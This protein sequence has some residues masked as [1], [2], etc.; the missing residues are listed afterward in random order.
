VGVRGN[1]MHIAAADRHAPSPLQ[2]RLRPPIDAPR[3]GRHPAR[4]HDGTT[5]IMGRV[6]IF[7]LAVLLSATA[8]ATAT[9]LRLGLAV[10][11]D[12]IDPH[13]HN[14]GGNKNLMPNLFEALTA[15]DAQDKLIPSLAVSWQALD[16]HTWEFKLRDG[17]T[18]S[19]GT[20]FTSDDVAF[21]ID[22]AAH[23]PTTFAD[24]SEYIKPI[25]RVEVVD[26]LTVRFHTKTPFPLAPE[27]L[28]A[29]GIVSRKHG[30]GATTADYNS[31]AAAIG[32]GPFRFVSWARGDRI[33]LARNDSWWG[34][35]PPSWDT[36]SIHYIK[37]PSSRLAA[38][39]A[40]DVDLI[41]KV[42]VQDIARIKQDP[43]FTVAAGLS[44]D[45]V[46]FVFDAQDRPSPQVTGNDGK[47]LPANPMHDVRVREA[48][49]LA[50]DRDAIRDRI[51]NSQ[52]DPDNQFM[53]PGQYGYDPAL[54]PPRFDPAEARH[55][56][57]EAGYPVGFHLIVSCQNDR[58]VNDA[59]I[60]Q[61]IA[62]MLTRIGIATTP[63]VMPH[64][65][66][67]PR[68]NRHEFSLCTYFWTIDTPEPS[69]M[70]VSQLATQDASRGRGAFNR[71]LYSNSAFDSVL[72][73]AL[74]TVDRE[75]REALMIKATDIAFRDVAVTPLHHQFN[76]EGM[77][78]RVRHTPRIDG[79]ILAAE[80]LPAEK[81]E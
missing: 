50:I 14:F 27:Y 62:Q 33:V 48:I 55:L 9:E 52:S 39:L 15:I 34:K 47:P 75:A 8:P 30:E 45:I 25:E 74:V 4:W 81:G 16:D 80:I 13:F 60:C 67:V 26:P 11:P 5:M 36:V 43:R 51:M 12:S 35:T 53:K 28:S 79:H 21:T 54:P 68:A 19:D 29:I 77:D 24:M 40:G 70:L 1:L 44:D 65:V 23:V 61:A 22:R 66:W 56:L 3:I 58:F 78:R 64:A 76:I 73:Q 38:L 41:D 49:S 72:D 37:N 20:K 32:T 7:L 57:A 31:G 6:F 17:V 59:T 42:A 46:G 10:E 18:F 69:I 2:P 71:G 63:E